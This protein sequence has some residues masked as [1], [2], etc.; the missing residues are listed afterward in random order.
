MVVLVSS[1]LKFMIEITQDKFSFSPHLV[2]P[3]YR[4]NN[5]MVCLSLYLSVTKRRT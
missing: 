2:S 3:L 5:L 1:S 4:K